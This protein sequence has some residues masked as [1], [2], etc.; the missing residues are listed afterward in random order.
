MATERN[1]FDKIPEEVSNVVPLAPVE[2]TDI[3][4]TFEVA[5]DGGVIVDF[6]SED[7]TMQPSEDIAEWYGDLCETL[8]E[9]ELYERKKFNYPPYNKLIKIEFKNR[10]YLLGKIEANNL[11]SLFGIE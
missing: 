9:N 6:A 10:I 11:I 1:P 4:A 5:D 7:V 3:D 2:N 8:D